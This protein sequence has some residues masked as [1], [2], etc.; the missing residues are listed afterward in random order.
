MDLLVKD[1]EDLINY[2][3][4]EQNKILKNKTQLTKLKFSLHQLLILYKHIN[5]LPSKYKK[6]MNEI[7]NDNEIFKFM[8][9]KIYEEYDMFQKFDYQ[10]IIKN[11]KDKFNIFDEVS[12]TKIENLD[13]KFIYAFNEY[14][15]IVKNFFSNYDVDYYNIILPYLDENHIMSYKSSVSGEFLYNCYSNNI[16]INV[17]SNN[18]YSINHI[19]ILVH[20]LGH[21]IQFL[22]NSNYIK[23]HYS[24]YSE[25]SSHFF[26][27]QF[28]KYLRNNYK[29]IDVNIL[30]NSYLRK[31]ISDTYQFDYI[32][33]KNINNNISLICSSI[34]LFTYII[35]QLLA[36]YYSELYD[37]DK[38]KTKNE[39]HN[40]FK[41]IGTNEDKIILNDDFYR[42][43]F[44]EKEILDN[45]KKIRKF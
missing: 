40:I 7:H 31:L 19:I 18:K 27:L 9:E 13:E 4:N 42:F 5:K 22:N 41:N 39:I 2:I 38:D 10:N 16:F 24:I 8:L 36:I 45:Q 3:D 23:S 20:E 1:I 25:F 14:M 17:D 15:D 44:L 29:D 28:L 11:I 37:I 35:G 30:I 26:Q 32:I 34:S 43:D 21:S 33:N 12:L 6:K